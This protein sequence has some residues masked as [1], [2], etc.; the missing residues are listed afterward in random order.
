MRGVGVTGN[1]NQDSPLLRGLTWLEPKDGLPIDAEAWRTA[2]AYHA[3]MARAH[4]LASHGSGVLV[5]LNV[6]PAGEMEIVVLPG[7]GIDPLGR[8]VVVQTLQRMTVDKSARSAGMLFVVA[9]LAQ[10]SPDAQGRMVEETVTRIATSPPAE[11]YLELARV[12]FG[13]A[14]AITLPADPFNPGSGEID[15]RYRLLAGGYARGEVAVA[16]IALPDAGEAHAGVAALIARAINLDGAYRARYIGRVEPGDSLP[17]ATIL[18]A[19]G[20]QDFTAGRSLAEWLTA[21][22]DHGGTLVGD[23]CHDSPADP[24]GGAFDKL[25]REVNRTMRRIMGKDRLLIAHH[26]FGAPPVGFARADAGMVLA[27]GGVIYMASDYGCMLNGSGNPAPPRPAIKAAEEFASNLAA[28]ACERALV[29]A[30]L[31]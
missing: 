29:T 23:G 19:A 20:N 26:L 28:T 13:S 4:N 12:N 27:E 31:E 16:E 24:F 14:A 17:D 10:G 7:V 8:F 30:Q 22:L 18:Y 25:S 21:F 11:P 6:V 2:H 3:D 5:G 1:A 15:T 9:L